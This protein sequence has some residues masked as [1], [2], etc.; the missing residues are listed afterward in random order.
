MND[1]QGILK[2]LWI[3]PPRFVCSWTWKS[4]PPLPGLRTCSWRK[5]KVRYD[6][7]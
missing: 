3:P 6:K 7:V 4:T 2:L 1:E 5:R